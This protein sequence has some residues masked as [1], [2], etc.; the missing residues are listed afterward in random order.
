MWRKEGESDDD[1]EKDGEHEEENKWERERVLTKPT[2]RNYIA[3][4]GVF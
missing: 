1:D 3:Q 4:V 2:Y